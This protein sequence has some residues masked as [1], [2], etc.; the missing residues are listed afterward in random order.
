MGDFNVNLLYY[1]DDKNTSNL[2]DAIFS[3]SFLPFIT[4]PNRIT[5]NSITLDDNIFYNKNL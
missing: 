2:L 4:T 3:Q 5:R 1:N